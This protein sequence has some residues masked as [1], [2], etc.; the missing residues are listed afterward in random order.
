M[1]G[2]EFKGDLYSY[3]ANSREIELILDE[4]G[5][6]EQIIKVIRDAKPEDFSGKI[7]ASLVK[8]EFVDPS[9]FEGADHCSKLKDIQRK[10]R[11]KQLH[12][13]WVYGFKLDEKQANQAGLTYAFTESYRDR[14]SSGLNLTY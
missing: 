10:I 14:Q 3:M 12:Y 8:T 7:T 11:R 13:I 2:Q 4:S 6:T 1:S 5:V 9:G